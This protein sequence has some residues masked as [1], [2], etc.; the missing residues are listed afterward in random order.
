MTDVCGEL[1]HIL[2]IVRLQ[3][4]ASCGSRSQYRMLARQAR[5]C[6]H[7]LTRFA[8]T[9][10]LL[11]QCKRRNHCASANTITPSSSTINCGL[12]Q[13]CTQAALNL[14]HELAG[15]RRGVRLSLLCARTRP[16]QS[17]FA[18]FV[19]RPAMARATTT[20][21]FLATPKAFGMPGGRSARVLP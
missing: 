8:E 6:W 1:L 9:W 12:S 21:R 3:G 4:C 18:D 13:Y 7:G 2:P 14:P 19:P 11:V 10:P 17:N 5:L 16:S 15:L 20:V